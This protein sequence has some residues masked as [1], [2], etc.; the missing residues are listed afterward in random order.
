M[1][2]ETAANA[3]EEIRAPEPDWNDHSSTTFA[4]QL[5]DLLPPSNVIV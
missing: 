3:I 2:R 5:L 4:D 1:T